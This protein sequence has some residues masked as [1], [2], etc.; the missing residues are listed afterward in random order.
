LEDGGIKIGS[1]A[2]SITT[3]SA[4]DM[5]EALVIRNQRIALLRTIPGIGEHTAQVII[6]EIEWNVP[7]PHRLEPGFLGG[8][9]PGQQRIRRPPRSPP[10]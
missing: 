1:V 3:K 7:P 8:A 2:S 4:R 10:S 6:S 9:V 5:I